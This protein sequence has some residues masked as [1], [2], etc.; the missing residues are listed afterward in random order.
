MSRFDLN[1]ARDF[2]ALTLG[3]VAGVLQTLSLLGRDPSKWDI[4]EG[5]YNGV[6]F[7]VFQSKSAY[8]AGLSQI[9][10]TGGRRK[11]KY[12]YPYKDGQTTDDLGRLPESFEIE[13]LIHGNRY[14]QGFSALLRELNKPTPGDLVHPVRG[15]IRC[16]PENY[17][18]THSSDS[19]KAV[20]M[21]I[22]FIEH[23]FTIGDIRDFK[24]TSVK[25]A[26]SR[27]LEI[28]AQVNNIITN[29][30]GAVL[31]AKSLRNQIVQGL[32]DYRNRFGTTLANMN[33]TFN[34]RGSADIPGLLPVN[35]GGTRNPDGT[36]ASTTFTTVLSPS[37]KFAQIP[38]S[39]ETGT[40]LA[41]S[42][43]TKDVVQLRIDLETQINLIKNGA[44]GQGAL[45]FYDD[46]LTLKNTAILMQ[47]ALEKGIASSRAQIVDFAVPRLMTLREVCFEI[48]ISVE[49][50]VEL[51]LL[52]PDLESTNFLP[53]DLIIKVPVI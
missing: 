43:I 9:S 44:Q 50:V 42:K 40:A 4:L 25:G 52:N 32:T 18:V 46:I 20:A 53:R 28:F 8:Q 23:N 14:M 16:V 24:D 35:Q 31:F 2:Q 33:L 21:R 29:I 15:K 26:L 11:V 22:T 34:N 30:T 5:S 3:S 10:D 37:D 27:A 48:G 17:Q 45:E 7:H 1:D 6:L 19:R 12:Q 38:I 41:V 13:V 39:E 36:A 47:D 51:D 49:R